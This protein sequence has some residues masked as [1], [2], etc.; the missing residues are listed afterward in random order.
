MKFLLF[1]TLILCARV[2]SQTCLDINGN[3]V[4]WWVKLLYPGS[5]SGGFGYF[6]ST[7]AAPSF[8]LYPQ[9]P[10]SLG[11]PLYNTLNQINVMNLQ[12]SAWND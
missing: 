9:D 8:V 2:H 10:D 7:Y 5:V 1:L 6:D 4:N 12:T 3:P 11:T